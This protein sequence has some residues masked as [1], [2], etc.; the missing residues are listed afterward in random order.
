MGKWKIFDDNFFNESNIGMNCEVL[1][2]KM[3][4]MK[5]EVFN[6]SK[7]NV[8]VL[9]WLN[10]LRYGKLNKFEEKLYLIVVIVIVDNEI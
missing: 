5:Y 9:I 8:E 10:N 3:I 7:G 2:E 1:F 6:R 4:E